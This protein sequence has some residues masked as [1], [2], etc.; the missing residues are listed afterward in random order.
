MSK[1]TQSINEPSS[2][3]GEAVGILCVL[4]EI[5]DKIRASRNYDAAMCNDNEA[6]VE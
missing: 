6:L 5:E 4:K 2:H 1:C 3:I